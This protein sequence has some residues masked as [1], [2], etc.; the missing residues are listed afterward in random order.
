MSWGSR[1]SAVSV[2]GGDA[3]LLPLRYTSN[4][5]G[6]ARYHVASLTPHTCHSGAYMSFRGAADLGFTRDRQHICQSRLKLTL[7]RRT[8]QPSFET[9]ATLAPQDEGPL[10]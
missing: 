2:D 9:L 4:S 7:V 1:I 6:Q 3:R 5:R 8:R 10:C